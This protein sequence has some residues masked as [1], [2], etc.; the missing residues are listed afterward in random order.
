LFNHPGGRRRLRCMVQSFICR[1]HA[2]QNTF[3]KY[4]SPHSSI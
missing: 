1:T 4:P 2:A 3:C